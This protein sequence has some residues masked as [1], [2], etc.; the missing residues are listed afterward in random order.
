MLRHGLHGRIIM[1]YFTCGDIGN[2]YLNAPCKEKVH[3]TIKDDLIF[4]PEHRNKTAVIVRALNGLKYAGNSLRQYLSS[5][6]QEELNYFPC[7]AD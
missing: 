7:Q 3:V 1:T 6:L 2:A 4:G 5:R